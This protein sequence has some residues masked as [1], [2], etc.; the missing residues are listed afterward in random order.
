MSVNYLSRI[1]NP[2]LT[3]AAYAGFLVGGFV[4]VGWSQA[5]PQD[6]PYSRGY[7]YNP[8]QVAQHLERL[9]QRYAITSDA[10]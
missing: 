5:S 2:V 8:Y 10:S 1:R 7:G 4:L 9:A 6:F 3:T